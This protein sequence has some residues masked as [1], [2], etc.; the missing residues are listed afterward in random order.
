MEYSLRRQF[1]VSCCGWTNRVLDWETNGLGSIPKGVV[2]GI[3]FLFFFL[4]LLPKTGQSR[5]VW[6]GFFLNCPKMN[7][8]LQVS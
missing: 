7:S 2:F 3:F 1:G 4:N 6:F 5:L 8:V